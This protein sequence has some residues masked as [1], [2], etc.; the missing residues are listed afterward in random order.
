MRIMDNIYMP[1]LKKTIINYIEK[2]G[3]NYGTLYSSLKIEGDSEIL[4]L[5][6]R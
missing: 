5:E 3:H 2:N 4:E 1:Q 6:K